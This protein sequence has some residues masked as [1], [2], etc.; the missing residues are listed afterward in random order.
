MIEFICK[1]CGKI[2]SR[3]GCKNNANVREHK[4]CSKACFNVV[5]T[6]NKCPEAAKL[7][8]AGLNQIEAAN[9]VSLCFSCYN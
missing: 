7:C 9:Q 2:T 4:Y 8:Q 1:Q 5:R 6:N 3:R